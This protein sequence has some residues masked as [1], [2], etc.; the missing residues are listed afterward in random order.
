MHKKFL[1]QFFVLVLVMTIANCQSIGQQKTDLTSNK[2]EGTS[3]PNKSDI[4][5]VTDRGAIFSD[6]GKLTYDASRSHSLA[7]GVVSVFGSQSTESGIIEPVEIGRFPRTPYAMQET[8][9][10]VRRSDDAIVA[11]E[12][13]VLEIQTELGKKLNSTKRKEVIIFIHGY[14]NTFEDA[15]KTTSQLCDSFDVNEYACVS[16]SWPAGGTQGILLG[17][18][19]DRESGEFAVADIRKAIRVIAGIQQ[20][21][22]MHLIAHSR[23]TDVLASALQQLMIEAYGSK[24]TIGDKYKIAN[25]ILAAPDID[26]DVASS[27]LAVLLSDPDFS[28]GG[29]INQKAI[30]NHGN[31]QTTIYTSQGDKAL[32][33][34]NKLF[35]G[36]FRLGMLAAHLDENVLENTPKVGNNLDLISVESSGG[37]FLG[38]SYFLANDHVRNDIVS[39]IRDHQRAGSPERQLIEIKRPFWLL[40]QQ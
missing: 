14:H 27:K 3:I 29:K 37:E 19:F 9:M 25:I 34:S 15:I 5:Y 16:L 10:G 32:A 4:F 33:I 13:S 18:N 24:Q 23:G 28:Y 1:K 17:Y 7:Y 38:H 35:G 30:L 11:H 2:S 21:K 39:L 36:Q 6:T 20:L 26:V 31:T 8:P 40:P 22:H 12:R